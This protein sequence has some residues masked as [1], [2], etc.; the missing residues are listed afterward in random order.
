MQILSN[1]D[2]FSLVAVGLVYFALHRDMGVVKDMV[3]R[4][5]T[6]IAKLEGLFH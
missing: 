4:L 2:P 3:S 5:D 6:R 1:F